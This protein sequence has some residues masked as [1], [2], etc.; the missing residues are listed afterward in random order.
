VVFLVYIAAEFRH[1]SH[2][3]KRKSV[4]FEAEVAVY[5]LQYCN[6]THCDDL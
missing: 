4:G 1:V 2:G 3:D 6:K 5:A